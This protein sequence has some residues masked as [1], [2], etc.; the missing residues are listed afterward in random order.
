MKGRTIAA[1]LMVLLCTA[2]WAQ[3]A[4]RVGTGQWLRDAWV[5]YRR[6]TAGAGAPSRTPSQILSTAV[7]SGLFV[8]FV[9]G[10]TSAVNDGAI[11]ILDIPASV[12]TERVLSIVGRYLDDHPEKLNVPAQTLVEESLKPFFPPRRSS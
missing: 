3:G 10:V 7:E 5:E 2:G 9:V 11:Q 8:G 12:P 6:S 4:T 1:G